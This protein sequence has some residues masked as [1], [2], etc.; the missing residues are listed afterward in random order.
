MLFSITKLN[1]FP[2]FQWFKWYF[3]NCLYYQSKIHIS[4]NSHVKNIGF[5]KYFASSISPNLLSKIKRSSQNFVINSSSL[6]LSK[7]IPSKIYV[8][9]WL[10]R[11][12]VDVFET[13]VS[14]SIQWESNMAKS[15][16]LRASKN[17]DF[18]KI[19]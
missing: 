13:V 7:L 19:I 10:S 6:G 8:F 16:V 1:I 11:F 9:W 12:Y 17:N 14:V 5:Q 2:E 18:L 3:P 4:S 15:I